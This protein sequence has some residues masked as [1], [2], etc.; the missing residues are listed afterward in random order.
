MYLTLPYARLNLRRNPFGELEPEERARLAVTAVDGIAKRLRRPGL[1]VQLLGGPGCGKTTHLL[2][3]LRRF[4]GAPFVKVFEGVQVRIPR[5]HPLF[6]DDAHLLPAARLRRALRRPASF[7]LTSHVD[8][9]AEIER[10]GLEALTVGPA[11]AH[12]ADLLGRVF[13]VRV[14]AA[15]RGPGPLPRV[16]RAAVEELVRRFGSD[17]RS[18]EHCLYRAFVTLGGVRDVEV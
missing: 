9:A 16:P 6:L 14:E 7:V 10:C 15:R 11:E 4:V 5:G 17:V 1:A 12:D 3:L 8:L 2:A 13:A 18:M